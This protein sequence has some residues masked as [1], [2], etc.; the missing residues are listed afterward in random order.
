[1]SVQI[2]GMD[3]ASAKIRAIGTVL[4][5]PLKDLLA[6]EGRLVAVSY[7]KSSQPYGTGGDAQK[8]GRDAVER[9]IKRVYL[10]PRQA[11]QDLLGYNTAEGR[12]AAKAFWKAY[13]EG[14]FKTALDILQ[15][16][17]RTL[18]EVKFLSAF[19]GGAAHKAARDPR[20]G[21]VR[22]RA[23]AGR[24][25]L[26]DERALDAYIAKRQDNVGYGKSGWADVA[27]QLGGIR[28]IGAK[29]DIS[30][31]WL[32]HQGSGRGRVQWTGN[33]DSLLLTITNTITYAD[34]ILPPTARREAVEIAHNRLI[35]NLQI[36]AKAELKKLRAAA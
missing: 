8:H 3:K 31:S 35:K 12:N 19:D 34:Q 36:A 16:N 7:V 9:D 33:N 10:Q 29:G 30:A 1:M 25:L 5:R 28:G 27:R 32:T 2:I 22:S 18:K 14:D 23:N 17:A 13:K 21:R 6:Q 11:Y 4:H 15:R 26:L 20:T 24:V